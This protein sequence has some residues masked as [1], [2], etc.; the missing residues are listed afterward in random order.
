MLGKGLKVV[1]FKLKRLSGFGHKMVLSQFTEN[2]VKVIVKGAYI[3]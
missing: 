1:S 2:G 3:E